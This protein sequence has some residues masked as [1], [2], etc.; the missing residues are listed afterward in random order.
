[1]NKTIIISTAI[2]KNT[3]QKTYDWIK[4]NSQL[5]NVGV[6]RA[7]E[8]LIVVTDKKAI[9]ILSKKDDDLYALIEYVEKNGTTNISQSVANKLTI[10]LS[11]DSK[12]ESEFYT[13]MSHYCSIKGSRFERNVKIIDVFPEEKN[14]NFVNKK[15]FDGV[16]YQGSEPK[17]VFELNGRE[18]YTKKNRI[19]SD[20]IK[21]ELLKAKGVGLM[22][23]P[24]QYVK[25][26][27]FIRE[28]INKFNGDVFE[29]SLFD[30]YD[31]SN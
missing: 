12:Y 22:F 19:K 31:F 4:N 16:L 10:G 29:K 23:I 13:T 30:S 14:N 1:E 27:E 26:Y 20:E 28:L 24:N 7:K 3:S 9:D 8:N 18:H 5:I 15:E 2:S 6:T 21:I 11:N 17:I 25:H